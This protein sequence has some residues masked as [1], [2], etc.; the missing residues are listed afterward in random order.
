MTAPDPLTTAWTSAQVEVMHALRDWALGFAE[1]NRGFAAW[2]RLP[3]SDADALGRIIWAAEAGSPLSPVQLA[4]GIGMT[5]GAT[6]ALVNRLEAAG[7]VGRSRE[8]PDRR[9]V[10]LRPSPE[11]RHRARE[12][13]A[14]AGTGIAATLQAADPA[15]LRAT[16]EF[17][18]RMTAAAAG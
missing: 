13:L 4:R 3:A 9:R 1:L 7:H 5:T 17:L 16:T 15:V 2:M 18:G 12:F 8:H 14:V 11:A 6:T 10:T